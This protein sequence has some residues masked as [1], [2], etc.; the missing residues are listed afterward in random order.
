MFMC[1]RGYISL[2]EG[3]AVSQSL[4]IQIRSLFFLLSISF[5]LGCISPALSHHLPL[6]LSV[7]GVTAVCQGSAPGCSR[8][9][10]LLAPVGPEAPSSLTRTVVLTAWG[11]GHAAG[12]GLWGLWG[13]PAVTAQT[14]G[15]PHP[16]AHQPTHPTHLPNSHPSLTTECGQCIQITV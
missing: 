8:W 11:P 9:P 16:T 1:G 12:P 14:K 15:C 7:P 6:S 10:R 2:T 13:R 5:P 4:Y 3:K